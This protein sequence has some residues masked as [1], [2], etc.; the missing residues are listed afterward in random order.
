MRTSSVPLPLKELADVRYHGVAV[1]DLYD[2]ASDFRGRAGPAGLL[3]GVDTG[4]TNATS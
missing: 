1:D 3:G 2:N 4:L